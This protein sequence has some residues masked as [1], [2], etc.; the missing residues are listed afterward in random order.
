MTPTEIIDL[1]QKAQIP[2]WKTGD[3]W[4]FLVLAALSLIASIMAWIQARKAKN[5]AEDAGKTVKIQTITIDL[6]EII[7]N[8]DNLSMD[9][10]FKTA[11]DLINGTNRKVIRLMTPFNKNCDYSDIIALIVKDLADAKNSLYEVKPL[12]ETEDVIKNSVYY[13][14][15]GIISALSGHLAELMGLFEKHTINIK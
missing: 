5:A 1:I 4:I 14:V 15:E 6:F 11:R 7:Q 2:F 13:A 9:I 8:L 3:F 12:S 10:N